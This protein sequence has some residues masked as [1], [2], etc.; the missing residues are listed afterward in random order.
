MMYKSE[1]IAAIS[2]APGEAGIGIVR[3][4]GDQ[5]FPIVDK[6]FISSSAKTFTE[7]K[8]RSINPVSYT[9]LWPFS[10]ITFLL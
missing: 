8:N 3:M 9:H 7:L 5:A 2:T 6:L 1:T 10:T 4:S